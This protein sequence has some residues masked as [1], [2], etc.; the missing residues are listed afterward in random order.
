MKDEAPWKRLI[1]LAAGFAALTEGMVT[2]AEEQGFVGL[3]ID[4]E[5][6]FT[7]GVFVGH[8][9]MV[10][11]LGPD[12]IEPL[13]SAVRSPLEGAGRSPQR[14]TGEAT[15]RCCRRNLASITR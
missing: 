5:D 3:R 9:Y 14:R 13:L 2:P 4:V 11:G 10:L 1:Q 8:G 7:G 15:A 12:V 6:M